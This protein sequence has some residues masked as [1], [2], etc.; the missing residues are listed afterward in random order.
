MNL[1]EE[2]YSD[3]KA[4]LPEL[5][6]ALQSGVGYAT[7]LGKRIIQWDILNN[8][9]YCLIILISSVALFFIGGYLRKLFKKFKDDGFNGDDPEL[10]FTFIGAVI[11][12]FTS[13]ILLTKLIQF[14]FVIMK[15][16]MLPELRLIEIVSKLL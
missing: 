12:Y 11:C 15:T 9:L 10:S 5:Q 1:P 3:F 4:M 14:L 13:F 6:E 2:M 16:V 8:Y 7:D